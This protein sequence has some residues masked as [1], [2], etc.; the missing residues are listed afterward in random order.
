M[1]VIKNKILKSLLGVS[2]LFSASCTKDFTEINTNPNDPDDA[3]ITNVFAQSIVTLSSRFGTNEIE[4]PASYV[5]YASRS[6]YNDATNYATTPPSFQW[7]QLLTEF[8]TNLNL[9]IKK[10]EEEK[11]DNTLGAA[12][13]IKAL[14]VQM[15][16]DSYGP[17]PYFEAGQ[18]ADGNFHPAFDSE[19]DIY[20]DLIIQLEK[21]NGLFD[22]SPEAAKIGSGDVLLG[23]DMDLWKKFGNSL[24]LRIAIRMSNIDPST[25]GIII[26]KILGDPTKYPI[27]DSND[28]NIA[29]AFP[30][31][32]WR[33][34]WTSASDNYVDIKI[35][36]PLV[37]MLKSLS[38]PRLEQ[39]ASENSDGEYV[40]LVIG[41]EGDYTNSKINSQF[42][43]NETGSVP[44]MKYTEIEFIKAEVYAKSLATGD[45]K[46]AYDNAIT[47]SLAEYGIDA[48]VYLTQTNVAWDNDINKLYTQKWIA[49]FRQSWE[50]WAEM[51][52]TDV[53]A[54]APAAN[55]DKTGHN[56]TPFRF[57]YPDSEKSLN[58]ANI[59][60]NVDEN[61]IYWGYQV[62]WDTRTGV[63]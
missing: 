49:L 8:S 59:P 32:D 13:V 22:N 6:Q 42:V 39:Y 47:A 43:S 3:P 11:L 44:F 27:L 63:N 62:W 58:G 54:L 40:G 12:L 10:A 52:R 35:G 23:N 21:A 50:A 60:S 46:T 36:A 61:D 55:S 15:L 41:A 16:V 14:G 26:S 38:D 57:A 20:S 2:I 45:A 9:V 51:R 33:E 48:T 18:G 56:R 28:D 29:L 37:D 31:D 19:K 34:P 7:T 5:G 17:V 25:S 4:Y 53:P 1:K 30:G 24:Q